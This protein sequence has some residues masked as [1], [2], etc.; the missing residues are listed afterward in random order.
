MRALAAIPLVLLTLSL[1]T[2]CE[3]AATPTAPTNV[4]TATITVTV[5]DGAWRPLH[6]ATVEIQD[7]DR[8]MLSRTTDAEGRAVF[9]GKWTN[10][11]TVRGS[12]QGF[13]SSSVVLWVTGNR[14][15]WTLRLPSTEPTINLVPGEYSLTLEIDNTC[16]GIPS[17]LRTRRYDA[18]V[19]A[20]RAPSGE[21]LTYAVSVSGPTLFHS[22]DGRLYLGV[23]GHD[24]V[25]S[26]DEETFYEDLPALTYLSFVGD[27]KTT[28]GDLNPSRISIPFD[29]FVDYCVF[30][31]PRD[32]F[33]NCHTAPASQIVTREFCRSANHQMVL[34]RR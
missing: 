7:G 15:G 32:R 31:K 10:P 24:L 34:S 4:V 14:A 6:N 25:L 3:Q 23:A 22:F 27:G 2:A 20:W 12:M 11:L 5:T 21:P 9:D 30:N 8:Q 19:E 28:V 17:E 18:T 26:T 1:A 33:T 29:G 13:V 16:A